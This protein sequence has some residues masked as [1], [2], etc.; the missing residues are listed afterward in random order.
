MIEIPFILGSGSILNSQLSKEL[1]ITLHCFAVEGVVTDQVRKCLHKYYVGRFPPRK[2]HCFCQNI[3][4]LSGIH[5][6]TIVRLYWSDQERL[7]LSFSASIFPWQWCERWPD[8]FVD[9]GDAYA[10]SL[11]PSSSAEVSGSLQLL[12]RMMGWQCAWFLWPF[13]AAWAGMNA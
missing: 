8:V 1:V 9:H 3:Q 13:Q 11:F 6:K 5:H 12:P 4:N 10:G 7:L 2:S